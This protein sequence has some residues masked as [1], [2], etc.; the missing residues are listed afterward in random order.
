MDLNG[1]WILKGFDEKDNEISVEASVP[2]CVHTDFIRNGIIKDLYFRDN[3]NSYRWVEKKNFTYEKT[4]FVDEVYGNAYIEFDGLDTYCDVFLNGTKIGEAD[5][6][7]IPYEFCADG[8]LKKGE[9]VLAVAFRPPVAEVKNMPEREG[10]FARERMNTRRM[11]CTYGWDWVDRFVT[12]GIYRDVRLAFRKP[13]EI[14]NVYVFTKRITPYSA[15]IKAEIEFRDVVPEK[16]TVRIKIYSPD[17]K[18]VYSKRRTI[19][20]E[21]MNESFDIPSPQLWYPSGYGEQPLYKLVIETSSS[22]KETVFGIREITVVQ[23]EDVPG[24]A[25]D[26]K[27]KEIRADEFFASREN[28]EKTACFTVVVNDI[29]IMCKG[30][31]WVPCEPFPSAETPEKIR[32]L[33]RLAKDAG[34]NMLRV[35][36]GG[37]FEQDFFYEECDRLGILVTQDFL[38]ACGTYPEKEEWFIKALNNEARAAAL[39]L[40]NHACLA[41]WTGDNENG[42]WGSENK[43]DFPG[44]LSATY[45]IEPML[46]KYD[47]ERYFFPSSPWGGDFY[48]SVTRGTTHNTNYQPLVFKAAYET[49]FNN[50]TEYFSKMIARFSVEQC[51]FGLPFISSLK[52]FMTDEDIYEDLKM[53]EFHTKNGIDEELTLFKSVTT[54]AEKMFGEYT[55]SKDRLKKQQMLQCEWIRI[56]FEAHRRNKWF[57]SGLLYWMLNDCWPAANGWSIIDYY[58]KPK[59]AYY[60]FKRCAKP[61]VVSIENKNGK[62]CVYACNDALESCNGKASLYLY[63][64][65]TGEKCIVKSF[66]FNVAEN[67]SELAFECDSSEYEKLMTG[68]SVIVCDA[69]SNLGNDRT[70]YVKGKLANLGIAYKNAEIISEDEDSITVKADE[71]TPCAL[72]DVPY[73]LEEN[74]FPMLAGETRR[75]RKIQL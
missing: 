13:N 56:T 12:M 75:I 30:A 73:L 47:R 29:K 23:L 55:D 7:F 39:R 6:M 21:T 31:N 32:R 62:L 38:M 1:K 15:Q 19:L 42:E 45:G 5:D 65:K 8:A 52:N 69:E 22:V 67:S 25:E 40:R 20:K 14:S 10:V 63:N 41:W 4:F 72:L 64:C 17:G 35:W 26:L 50:Y 61:M 36:G 24:S 48:S 46:K 54:M 9:N 71:F 28:H 33:L 51:C 34:T 16:N 57:S 37:I 2:G 43:N 44:Y 58:A 74:C 3:V 27:C 59:P 70:F 53:H 11:Q 18:I 66:C 60:S 49:D 68:D